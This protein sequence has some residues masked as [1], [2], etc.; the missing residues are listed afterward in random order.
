[1]KEWEDRAKVLIKEAK[2]RVSE[3]P[4]D[5][6]LGWLENALWNLEQELDDANIFAGDN[7]LS[8][9]LGMAQ[10]LIDIVLKVENE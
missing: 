9:R 8:H 6:P 3:N 1:M 10:Q 7:L 5:Y 4:S 2:A